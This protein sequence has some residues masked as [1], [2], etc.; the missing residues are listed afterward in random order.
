LIRD[1]QK[2]NGMS[3]ILVSHDLGVVSQNT[4]H[5]IVMYAG[6]IVESGEKSQIIRS[7][8]ESYTNSHL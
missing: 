5:L 1:L 3:L 6:Q 8:K 4:D 7:P 2:Q